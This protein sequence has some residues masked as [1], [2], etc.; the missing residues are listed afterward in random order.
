MEGKIKEAETKLGR[1]TQESQ[2]PEYATNAT[3]L[4]AITQEI[5][6]TQTEIEKL[7]ARWNE[8]GERALP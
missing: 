3:Q 6:Q 8:L 4:A 1:L 7:F 2:R 5:H